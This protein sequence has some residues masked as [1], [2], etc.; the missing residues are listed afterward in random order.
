MIRMTSPPIKSLISGRARQ[1]NSCVLRV[2]LNDVKPKIW[3]RF[4]VPGTVLLSDL[5]TILLAVMGWQGLHLHEFNFV[6]GTYGDAA[7][8]IESEVEDEALIS[9][10]D[11]LNGSSSFGWVYDYCGLWIHHIELERTKN[12]TSVV[13][14][15]VCSAGQSACPPEDIGGAIG[16]AEFLE[17]IQ[18]TQHPNHWLMLRKVNGPFFPKKFD[19]K[20]AQERLDLIDL[21]GEFQPFLN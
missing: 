10:T 12:V 7:E 20:A 6:D 19:R 4:S 13:P 17:A 14:R 21:S 18:D 1:S 5:H 9:L 15:A 8:E 3:R 2:E 16:Y 11:A